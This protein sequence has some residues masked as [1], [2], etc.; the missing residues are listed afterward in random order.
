LKKYRNLHTWE[1]KPPNM[2][3]AKKK[4]LAELNRQRMHLHLKILPY[5]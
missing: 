3:E 5:I 4:G 1:V 2:E